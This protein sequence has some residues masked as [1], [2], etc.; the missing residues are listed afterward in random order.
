MRADFKVLLDACVLINFG[1]CDLFLRLAEAPRMLFPL[2]TGKILEEVQSTQ[3]SRLKPPWPKENSNRWREAVETAFP[4]A[5]ITGY[6]PLKA[7]V[8]ND[9]GDRH[10]LAAAIHGQADLIVTFN[11]RH[12]PA[13]ALNMWSMT[14][15]HPSDYLIALYSLD[16]GLVVSRLDAIARKRQ[17]PPERVL[18]HLRKSL[19][20]FAEHVATSQGWQLPA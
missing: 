14:A 20:A 13:E 16:P 7:Q 17:L 8:T 9:T 1:L 12:F 19:P 15:S 10:V 2:W 6:E 11:L 3:Q 5:M 18:A 4:E